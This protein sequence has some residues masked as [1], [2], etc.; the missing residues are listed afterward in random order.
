MVESVLTRP[1][2][3]LKTVLHCKSFGIW[4]NAITEVTSTILLFLLLLILIIILIIITKI[5]IIT[6]MDLVLEDVIREEFLS[7]TAS[8]GKPL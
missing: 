2:W 6:M 4:G 3:L 5:F 7:A 1:K 8:L